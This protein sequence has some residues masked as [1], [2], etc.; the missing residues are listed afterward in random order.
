MTILI[1]CAGECT[2]FDHPTPKQLMPLGDETVLGRIVRQAKGYASEPVIVTH[3]GDIDAAF[4]CVSLYEPGQ[5][6]YTCETLLSTY[7]LWEGRVIVLLGDVIYS[8][9]AMRT[10]MTHGEL[11]FF[12]DKD[13]GEIVGLSFERRHYSYMLNGLHNVIEAA[14]KWVGEG[15]GKLWQLYRWHNGLPLDKHLYRA[16]EPGMRR[17]KD[18]TTDI[19]LLHEYEE[20]MRDFVGAGLLDDVPERA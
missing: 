8:A 17:I 18:W 6:R 1:L 16:G 19:D 9:Q 7:T 10:I 5:R 15:A 13:A 2:R 20:F 4:P 11:T 3:V 12:T 14:E